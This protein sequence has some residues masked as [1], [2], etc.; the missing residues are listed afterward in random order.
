MGGL[1]SVGFAVWTLWLGFSKFRWPTQIEAIE[2]VDA[3]LP[4]RPIS[5]LNDT[6]AI[7]SEDEASQSVWNAH[8]A[9]MS[10]RLKDAR[11]VE[12]DL[13]VSAKDPFALRYVALVAF[14]LALIFGSIFHVSSV[15]DLTPGEGQN[16]AAGPTWEGWVEPPSYTG[17]PSLYLNDID[18][19]SF[20]APVGSQITLR[21]YGE[22]GALIVEETVSGRTGEV[23]SASD[24]AQT[25]T[26]TQQGELTLSG[27]GGSS[28]SIGVIEDTFPTVRLSGPLERTATGEFRQPFEAEDDYGVVSGSATMELDLDRADRRYGLGLAPEEREPIS[29]DLPMTISGDRT[30]FEETLI[31]DLAKHPWAN[32]PIRMELT[33]EDAIGQTGG[34]VAQD[35]IL[36]GRRF[37][38]PL[39]AAV[40]EQRRDLLWNRKNAGR[41]S[42]VLRAVSH[43][44]D[45]VFR[46]ETA[47]LKLRV[48]IRRLETGFAYD[49]LTD[50]LIEETADVLWEIAVQLEEGDL[51]DALERLRRAQDR[52]SEAIE[53][54]A[55]DDEIAQLMQEL[56]EAMQDYMQQLAEQSGEQGENQQAQ[57]Q[58]NMQELSGDQLQDML[59]RLQ[60]LMEQGR[61]EEAQRLLDQL[62]QMM[63]NMQVTQGQPGQ[64]GQQSPGQ[65]AMEGLAETLRQQQGLSDEAFGDLQEQ[66]NPNGQQGQQGQQPGP[67]G[68][69]IWPTGTATRPGRSKPASWAGL[70]SDATS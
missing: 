12:P 19:D 50:E 4:G 7:G 54:G 27:P 14:V 41:V 34:V 59:N 39:A 9:R 68:S 18:R 20:D 24:P 22:I 63:E 60:E 51:S 30:D 55:T 36:P 61:M 29:L 35:A 2:R 44:P 25:F 13:K 38:D 45:E 62:R 8:I 11:M 15:A 32:L 17:R 28:W 40:I 6:Q 37:F 10:T 56:R 49:T 43:R 1:F 31:D 64:N 69:A 48:A 58:E 70:R 21:L 65:Q 42:Q 67:Q 23:L 47:F 26:I 3:T 57:N 53:N 5:A 52:L 16:L 66:F 33:V 46:S